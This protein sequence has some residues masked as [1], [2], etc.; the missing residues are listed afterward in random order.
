MQGRRRNTRTGEITTRLA[1]VYVRKKKKYENKTTKGN[2]EN[3]LR[4]SCD[5][6]K[7]REEQ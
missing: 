7:D 5:E 3:V 2:K 1:D 6:N 4:R